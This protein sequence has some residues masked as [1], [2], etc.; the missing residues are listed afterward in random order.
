MSQ[1]NVELVRRGFL[2]FRR[3]DYGVAFA[4]V[5]REFIGTHVAP[6]PDVVSYHGPDGMRQM[7]ADWV[8]G[9]NEFDMAVEEFID[10]NDDQVVARM[11][12]SAVGRGSRV[13]V[14]A[15][16]W[17]VYTLRGQKLVRMEIYSS[18]PQALK[19]VGLEK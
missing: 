16:F 14:E 7:L 10:A 12:Q 8:E 18:G 15:D 13:R 1:E 17:F 4:S 2:A 9:F 6:M 11:R 19:A 5:D 3:G